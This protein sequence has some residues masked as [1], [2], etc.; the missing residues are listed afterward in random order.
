MLG[1]LKSWNFWVYQNSFLLFIALMHRRRLRK[2]KILHFELGFWFSAG[3]FFPFFLRF[4]QHLSTVL[5]H[6]VF[7][8]RAFASTFLQILMAIL[9]R[10]ATSPP[11]LDFFVYVYMYVCMW[12]I[13]FFVGNFSKLD[14]IVFVGY[15]ILD[16]VIMYGMFHRFVL[17]FWI[18][19]GC[20]VIG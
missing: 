7:D 2:T 18:V 14:S 5:Y 13:G 3:R 9:L 6:V 1:C 17:C 4:L 12:V 8:L 20:L 15:S 11:M 10:W 16:Q 19:C